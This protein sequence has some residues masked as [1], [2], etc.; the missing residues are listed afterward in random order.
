MNRVP[1]DISFDPAMPVCPV[2][3][4]TASGGQHVLLTALIDTGADI[5]IVSNE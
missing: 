4:A 1:Y 2:T 5:T 3:F